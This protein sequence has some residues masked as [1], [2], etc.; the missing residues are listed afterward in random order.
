MHGQRCVLQGQESHEIVGHRSPQIF[1]Q[2]VAP[3]VQ[4]TPS[5]R[6]AGKTCGGAESFGEAA[7]NHGTLCYQRNKTGKIQ[8]SSEE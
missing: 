2:M 4:V 8:P 5:S 6:R 1:R 3:V 7:E